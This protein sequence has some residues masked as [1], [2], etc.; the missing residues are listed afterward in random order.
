M[1]PSS[2]SELTPIIFNME[3]PHLGSEASIFA[4]GYLYTRNVCVVPD[5]KCVVWELKYRI[6]VSLVKYQICQTKTATKYRLFHFSI[7]T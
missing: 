3:L 2:L 4:Y 1:R 5:A 6:S 7:L